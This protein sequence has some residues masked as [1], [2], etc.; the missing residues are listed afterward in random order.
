MGKPVRLGSFDEN[1]V[2]TALQLLSDQIRDYAPQ[3]KTETDLLA[4]EAVQNYVNDILAR[5][6]GLVPVSR[7]IN[8]IALDGDVTLGSDDIP[9]GSSDRSITERVNEALVPV[10]IRGSV[11]YLED[12]PAAGNQPQDAWIVTSDANNGNAAWLYVWQD[13]GP[14]FAWHGI[15][16]FGVD[17]SNFYTKDETWSYAEIIL[18]QQRQDAHTLELLNVRENSIMSRVDTLADVKIAANNIVVNNGIIEARRLAMAHADGTAAVLRGQLVPNTRRVNGWPL[19]NDVA[20]SA[21]DIEFEDGQSVWSKLNALGAAISLRHVVDTVDDLPPSV[22]NNDGA[23]VS[24]GPSGNP[25]I[26]VVLDNRWTHAAAFVVNLDMFYTKPEVRNLV[27]LESQ[28]AQGA[29]RQLQADIT[30]ASYA[31]LNAA[32]NYTDLTFQAAQ[33]I[34]D[35][36]VDKSFQPPLVHN[37]RTFA[38]A[39]GSGILLDRV[40]LNGFDNEPFPVNL[41]VA[42]GSRAGI[43]DNASFLRLWEMSDWIMS[44]TIGGTYVG[45][46]ATRSELNGAPQEPWWNPNDWAIVRQDET[47]LDQFGQ[48]QLTKYVLSSGMVWTFGN[49]MGGN[50]PGPFSNLRAGLIRGDAS[51][52]GR[53]QGIDEEGRAAVVGWEALNALITAM[54]TLA[55]IDSGGAWNSPATGIRRDVNDNSRDI[56]GLRTDTDANTGAVSSLRAFVGLDPYNIPYNPPSGLNKRIADNEA[57]GAVNNADVNVLRTRMANAEAG[58]D[59]K[60]DRINQLGITGAVMVDY[61][62]QGQVVGSSQT[63]PNDRVEGFDERVFGVIERELR[64]SPTGSIRAAIPNAANLG[65]QGTPSFGQPAQNGSASTWARSDHVHALPSA[66]AVRFMHFITLRRL[67]S[68]SAE[69]LAFIVID[70]RPTAHTLS[71]AWQHLFGTGTTF[72]LLR[73]SGFANSFGRIW[74]TGSAANSFRIDSAGEGGAGT[75]WTAGSLAMCLTFP[76]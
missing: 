51:A 44:F 35:M 24:R 74:V 66:Q 63:M 16:P 22:R 4:I 36:K 12:L 7:K 60:V 55:G 43:I 75:P 52:A 23:I 49:V 46:F 45:S 41:P 10:N 71:S 59:N 18:D 32:N 65:N 53:I 5:L 14:G 47:Q 20:L 29:E 15:A 33:G 19:V 39:L 50:M 37:I 72:P 70:Q 26:W 54:R 69:E 3:A 27:E 1:G 58:L 28:R 64:T 73:Q 57:M 42:D 40:S 2:N 67:V 62:N 68:D 11:R 6:D 13:R 31:T 21:L 56:D 9:F 30:S 25:E 17:L 8:G 76:L 48:P 34:F 38:D 61:N